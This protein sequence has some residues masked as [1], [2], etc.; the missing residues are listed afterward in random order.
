MSQTMSQSNEYDSIDELDEL[1]ELDFNNRKK[2]NEEE[3][4]KTLLELRKIF[5]TELLMM[6]LH[7]HNTREKMMRMLNRSK[8]LQKNEWTA[9]YILQL[10]TDN[11]IEWVKGSD[12]PT[13]YEKYKE[14]MNRTLAKILH[15][16]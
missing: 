11:K 13:P 15:P 12:D 6:T 9:E 16:V 14:V 7:H 10:A 1:D 3:T 8:A 2:A 5:H 4:K